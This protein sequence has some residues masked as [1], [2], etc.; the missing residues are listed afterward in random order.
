MPKDRENIS[1]FAL[2][3]RFCRRYWQV[4]IP[5]WFIQRA[6]GFKSWIPRFIFCFDVVRVPIDE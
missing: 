3:V 2:E 4:M 5:I 6:L 1:K